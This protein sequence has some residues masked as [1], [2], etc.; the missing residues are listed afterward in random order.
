MSSPL[1]TTKLYIPP[2]RP[3][4]APRPRLIE[5]LNAGLH[6]K[7]IF[8]SAPAGFGK[9]MLL[10]EWT[11]QRG[12]RVTPPLQVAWVSLDKSD[13]D[14]ARFWAYFVAAL[15]TVQA[16]VGEATLAALRSPQPPPIE[17]LLTGLINEIAAI[18]APF[19]LALDDYHLIEAQPIH[20][21]LTFL[22]DHL[23]PQ[24][25]LVIATRA[26]PPLPIARLRARGQ[27]TE[28]R[29]DDLR[30]TVEEAT[31]L[32]NE[33]MG[34]NLSAADMNALEARTEGWIVGLQMAALSM[35][36]RKDVSAFI[37]AFSGSHRF[38]L[39]Y[40]V[41][42]VLDQ[43]PGDVQ[44]FLLRT[45]I[46]E[47]M[48][49][50]LCDVITDRD[51]SQSILESLEA[52]NLFLVPLDDERHWYRYHHLFSDLL[53]SRLEHT[54]PN[55]VPTLHRQASEWYEQNGLIAEAVG[56][57]L[58][59][60][61][62]ERATRLIERAAWSMLARCEMATLLGWLDALPD[63][64]VRSRSQ[65]GILRAWALAITGQWDDVEACLSSMALS[66]VEGEAAAVRA[67][68]AG[69]R[70]DVPRTIQLAQQAQE[71]LP[72][73]NLFLRSQAVLSLGIAYFSNG[74]PVAASR[75]LSEAITLS[76]AAGQTY[77]TLA[78]M[79][80][81]GH[82]QEKQGLLRQAAHTFHEALELAAVH[83][84]RPLPVA[85]MAYVGL[86]E[87]LYEWNDLDGALRHAMEGIRLTKLGGFTSY[88]LAGY[89]RL[90]Q[91]YQARGEVKRALEVLGKAEQ[92]VRRHD[93]AYMRGVI[94][95]LRA[96]LW[97]V[98]GNLTPASQWA[99]ARRVS[100]VD[101]LDSAGE[102]EQMTV[103]RVLIAQD[104]SSEA[105]ELL[106][107]LLEAAQV[108]E[109]MESVIKIMTLK[110]LAFQA[111]GNLDGALSVLEQALSLVE[112]EGYV[113]T[114]VDEGEP[115]ARLLRHAL[116]Q[117]IAPNYVAKLLAAF[118]EEVQ[119]TP[120]AMKS[121]IE[122]LSERE[123]EVLRL[124]VAGLSNPEIARELVIAVSTVK[125]HVNHIYGKLGVESRTRAVARAR[126]LGLL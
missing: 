98:Q 87:V 115:M 121:L 64:L 99:Q 29:A 114:F 120:S 89:A 108:V 71:Q 2:P 10:S 31:G 19:V 97:V 52:A 34:L 78:A 124:I 81:L 37:K 28:L 73:D 77:V 117:G 70:G 82:V 59:A 76:Q 7:L 113:R 103:A 88:L 50:P 90:V 36:G 14:P 15:Q 49:A 53:C 51:D 61:D 63:D 26:D 126:E 21:A 27:L 105:L 17:I 92:L 85:G 1:L 80:A 47:R 123:L 4:L 45:S 35:R 30:F 96:R 68:I 8:I 3:D 25:H 39:D 109:R 116:S 41:E 74:E 32:L 55:Q 24:M 6:H 66:S 42:E 79:M 65:L 102:I 56:H 91:A 60:S 40:L 101:E 33:V 38:V 111:Q 93:Y 125:S 119:V 106:T 11:H 118:G 62:F 100:S 13:N 48:T 22:L 44:E 84:A 18:P 86:A 94:A 57:A 46:L 20:E 95:G 104:R 12:G 110:T 23:P 5:R 122:P 43:Q 69:V 107:W 58:A 67:Y 112:P 54:Q 72:R 9:T 16:N 75:A 83:G